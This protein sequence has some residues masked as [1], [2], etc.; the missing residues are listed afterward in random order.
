MAPALSVLQHWQKVLEAHRMRVPCLTSVLVVPRLANLLSPEAPNCKDLFLPPFQ[1]FFN[2][3]TDDQEGLYSLYFHKC[4][5]S[6]VK[7]GEQASFS[8]NVST[9]LVLVLATQQGFVHP[10]GM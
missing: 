10:E 4:P 1:F 2:I 8:L 9:S 5:G 6:N 7:P 3:S